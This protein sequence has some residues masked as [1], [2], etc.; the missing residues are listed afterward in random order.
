MKVLVTGADGLVGSH[1]IE[2]ADT[3]LE[4]ITPNYEEMD[5]T[6]LNSVTQKFEESKPEVVIHFAAYTDVSASEK[7][8]DDKSGIVWRVN[9]EGSKNI[10]QASKSIGAFM[11]HIS[12]DSVFSGHKN[13]PGPYDEDFPPE[14]NNDL[15][16]WYGCSKKEAEKEIQLITKNLSIVRISNPARANY[17]KKLDY[18]RKIIKLFDE[19]KLYPMF[20]DQH[21]TL[22]Y[23]NEVTVTLKSL[24]REKTP[25]IYHVSSTNLFTPFELANHVIEKA[26]GVKESVKASSIELFLQEHGSRYPQFGGLK[27]EKTRNKLNLDFLKWEEAVDEIILDI[28]QP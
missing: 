12:T 15:L 16:S 7:E 10:A 28:K 19:G 3:N 18:I 4:L 23:I 1:L 26:R 9:V 13:N 11:I 5:V 6:D 24:I 21:L 25:G 14:E 27:T 17:E 2:N 20:S 22:T 8:R